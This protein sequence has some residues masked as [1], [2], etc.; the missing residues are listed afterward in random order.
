MN[1]VS[2]ASNFSF[3]CVADS[4]FFLPL[5]V[6]VSQAQ[7][8]YP[9]C[10]FIIYD[11]GL[12]DEQTK[13]LTNQKNVVIRS[14]EFKYADLNFNLST[15]QTLQYLLRA[16]TLKQLAA[17]IIKRPKTLFKADP[18]FNVYSFGQKMYNKM[19]CIQDSLSKSDEKLLVIDADAFLINSIDEI[20]N[21]DFDLGVTVRRQPEFNFKYNECTILNGGV[22]FLFGSSET[23]TLIVQDWLNEFLN[24][25]EIHNE[26]TALTRLIQRQLGIAVFEELETKH[27]LATSNETRYSLRLL[28]CDKYNFNWIEEYVKNPNKNSIKILHFKSGRFETLLFEEIAKELNIKH[29]QKR[30]N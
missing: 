21:D 18:L 3:L 20:L 26:Q 29:G 9:E 7:R 4:R 23:N 17:N 16:Q 25:T 30:N 10:K 5:K 19:L 24:N 12:T 11:W 15:L 13:H 22:V 28:S 27:T 14:W 8:F 2:Q 6:S 1:L